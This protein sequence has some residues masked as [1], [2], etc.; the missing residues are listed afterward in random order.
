MVKCKYCGQ[1]YKTKE[2]LTFHMQLFHLE[3]VEI[4]H[5]EGYEIVVKKC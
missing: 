4:D 2:G 5:P 3:D 1:W